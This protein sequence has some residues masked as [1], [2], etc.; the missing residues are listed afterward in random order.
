M[1]FW[2]RVPLLFRLD[3]R[4]RSRVEELRLAKEVSRSGLDRFDFD[5]PRLHL[6]QVEDH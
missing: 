6:C 1:V 4:M 5:S 3:Q 2:G